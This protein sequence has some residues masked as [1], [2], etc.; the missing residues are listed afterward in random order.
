MSWLEG[1]NIILYRWHVYIN[2]SSLNIIRF[3]P[4]GSPTRRAHEAINRSHESA[5]DDV[6]PRFETSVT[7]SRISEDVTDE[8]EAKLLEAM[9][10]VLH[11]NGDFTF[12]VDISS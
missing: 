1:F 2:L 4:S 5:R 6:R 12:G 11:D 8:I 10:T 3:A 9:K 7:F